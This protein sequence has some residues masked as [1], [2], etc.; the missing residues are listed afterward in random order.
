M[1]Q[2]CAKLPT[3]NKD[4]TLIACGK[5]FVYFGPGRLGQRL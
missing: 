1:L 3:Q 4:I 5:V 2:L